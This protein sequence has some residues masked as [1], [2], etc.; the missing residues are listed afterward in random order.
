MALPCI[1]TSIKF[2]WPKRGQLIQVSLY[3]LVMYW[4]ELTMMVKG[5]TN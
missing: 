2:V 4:G 1:F 3:K 5:T